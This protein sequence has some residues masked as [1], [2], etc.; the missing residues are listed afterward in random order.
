MPKG[1]GY[2][3]GSG[4]TTRYDP[5]GAPVRKHGGNQAIHDGK[6]SSTPPKKTGTR[7]K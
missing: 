1:K 5:S 2:G 3:K 6:I 7:Q 4:G